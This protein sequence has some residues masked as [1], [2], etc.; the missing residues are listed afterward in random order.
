LSCCSVT[1]TGG[2][3]VFSGF[4]AGV[5]KFYILLIFYYLLIKYPEPGRPLIFA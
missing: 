2:Q 3:E 4:A 5:L 1:A